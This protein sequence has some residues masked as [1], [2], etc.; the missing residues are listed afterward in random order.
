MRLI[1]RYILLP[2][3]AA[4]LVAHANAQST[5]KMIAF[6]GYPEASQAEL[7]AASGFTPGAP[8][9][10]TAIQTAA[11]RLNDTGMFSEV[12]YASDGRT[13]SFILKP[14]TNT[15]P[16]QFDNFVWWNQAVLADEVHKRVP[17]FHGRLPSGSGMEQNVTDAL[18]A[19]LAAKGITATV[20][21]MPVAP[22]GLPP[23][24]VRF[25]ITSPSIRISRV[26]LTGI[27]PDLN[28]AVGAAMRA[29]VGQDY[30]DLNT[31]ATLSAAALNPCLDAGYL[32]ATVTQV[33]HG[34]PAAQGGGVV[35]SV[36]GVIAEGG[37]YRVGQLRWPGSAYLSQE[38]F[39]K[40]TPLKMGAPA[41]N[42]KLQQMVGLIKSP[43]EAKGFL[44]ADVE[45]T[46]TYDHAGHVVDYDL[47]VKSGP[48]FHMRRLELA[49]GTDE[50]RAQVM[51]A[52]KMRE[53]DPFDQTYVASFLTKNYKSMPSLD[54]YSATWKQVGDDRGHT[55][56]VVVT[57]VKGGPLHQ[58][59][60]VAR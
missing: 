35:V 25:E 6:E 36:S 8:F 11:Q 26:D 30:S 20:T 34:P 22:P 55:V 7:L 9:E 27:S 17:L 5:L 10:K 15:L 37:V 51:A 49:N 2:V 47:S 1:S 40:S 23:T 16:A 44:M 21:P 29:Q 59:I 32:D 45:A 13:L 14:A 41:S 3:W 43:Y 4:L 54:G 58:T 52:W 24:S 19:L 53:G 39:L 50:Q 60:V 42:Q 18:T 56:D 33:E 48:Q 31:P 57:L 28:G 38:D 12:R 46:P